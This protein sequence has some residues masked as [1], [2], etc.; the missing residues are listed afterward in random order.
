MRSIAF[1]SDFTTRLFS[2]SA[3][4]LALALI[5]PVTAGAQSPQSDGKPDSNK[6]STDINSKKVTL[7]LDNADIRY[8][9]KLLFNTTGASYTIEQT[10][11]GVV[12]V[13][14]KDV[15]FRTALENLLRA[16]G[17]DTP[18][19]YRLEDGVYNITPKKIA[20]EFVDDKIHPGDDEKPPAPITRPV[21]IQLNFIDAHDLAQILGG[22]VL[23]TRFALL[24][25]G[26]GNGFG[27]GGG[28]GQGGFGQ[29]GGMG[30]GGF[31]QGG[32]LG[33]G[34]FG[35]GG[36]GQGGF[37]QGNFGGNRGGNQGGSVGGN[38]GGSSRR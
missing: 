35:Q 27:Q 8:A 9:L 14:L 34:G 7:E 16:T 30:Q 24:V 21:K 10:V 38:G 12:S 20:A 5:A 3:A 17:S 28:M 37:G 31:G 11:R 2:F 13:S 33:Q 19:T 29:G 15:G 4:A 23:E 25:G 1:R 6:S 26:F 36:F 18:L 22:Q 32:G